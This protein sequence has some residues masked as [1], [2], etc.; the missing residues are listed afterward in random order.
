MLDMGFLPGHPAGAPAPA[1]AR[2]QTLFFC[3]TMPAADREAHARDAPQSGHHQPRA[4]SRRRPSGSRRR[5]YPVPAGAQGARSSSS[6]SSGA[7][8]RKRSSSPAPSTAPTGCRR[9]WSSTGIKAER[10]HGNRSQAQR[11]E[12]LAGFKDGKYRVLV[13]T[14]IAA[15]GIDVEALGHVV[16]FDVP[17]VPEDYIHRVGRTARAEATGDAFTF[18]APEEEARPA[19]DR[20]GDRPK[21][22]PRIIVPDFDYA[23]AARGQARDSARRADR[24]DPGQEGGG[25][26]A[27]QGQGGAARGERTGILRRGRASRRRTGRGRRRGPGADAWVGLAAAD[28]RAAAGG[29]AAGGRAGVAGPADG[30]RLAEGADFRATQECRHPEQREGACLAA[31]PL[32]FARVTR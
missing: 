13:A 18:V 26:G 20:A 23:R 14:D 25:P 29:P 6:C 22:L 3:A 11:T 1:R 8:C 21:R 31:C 12:A 27:R 2:R 4:R 15:R 19:R 17:T 16:N 7:R 9:T 32:R 5:V 28:G 10:I 24:A 30:P